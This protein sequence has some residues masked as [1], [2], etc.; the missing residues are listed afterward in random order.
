MESLSTS[1]DF[2]HGPV[3]E[4]LRKDLPHISFLREQLDHFYA[5]GLSW[6]EGELVREEGKSQPQADRREAK[7]S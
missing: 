6:E 1:F 2:F 7:D 4:V 3:A 5:R